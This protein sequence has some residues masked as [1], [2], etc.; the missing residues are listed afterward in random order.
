M[1]SMLLTFFGMSAS[2]VFPAIADDVLDGNAETLGWLWSASGAGALVGAL[3]VTPLLHDVRRVGLLAGGATIFAGGWLTFFSFCTWLP[4]SVM[5][6]FLSGL[7]YP[8]I[9]TTSVG[10]LQV[11][12]PT[13]MRGRLQS[14]LLMVTFAIQPVAALAT[15][16]SA[17]LVGPTDAVRLNAVLM[18][19]GAT[20]LLGSGRSLREWRPDTRA[21]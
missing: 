21:G 15:G 8:V 4:V 9:I 6:L 12:G 11:L 7:A 19:T 17:A 16:W 14:A 2:N 10:M 1:F 20:L 18:I 3:V 5:C 13:D